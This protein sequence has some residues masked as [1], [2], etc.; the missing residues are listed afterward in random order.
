MKKLYT[1]LL[2]IGVVMA[3]Q[4][5]QKPHYTQYILNNYILN[6]ALT[7][8]ENYF[9]VKVSARDQWVGL[10]GAPRTAYLSVQGPIDKSDTKTTPT[11]FQLPGENPR[12]EAYW[13]NYTASKPHSGIGLILLNDHTGNFNNFTA[14]VT[15]AYHI[16]L[17][18]TMNLSAGFGAGINQLHRDLSKT[19]FGD[20]VT[21]DPAQTSSNINKLKP[22]L[23]A[24][25]WLYSS[26]FF[27]GLSAQQIIPAAITYGDNTAP[28]SGKAVPHFF[29]TAGYRF[30]LND[31]INALP[32]VMVKYVSNTPTKPQVDANIKLQYQDLLWLGGS[33]RFQD[34]YAAMVGMNV[35]NTFNIGYSYDFT[36][37]ALNTT[38]KGTHEIIIGFLIGNRYG[39]TCP[40]NV[41]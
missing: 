18:P 19:D 16:G 10:N 27:V 6:P 32:S 29:A 35:A 26:D 13:E 9:D 4:A 5:Q 11:S 8:I 14:N 37:T 30:L 25:L 31:D 39:D 2:F 34:G 20:G 3:V 41:W 15:Y 23:N 21:V 17:T 24:G 1:C 38:S 33:Y 40:R 22:D 36:K 7:G 28:V 12:G